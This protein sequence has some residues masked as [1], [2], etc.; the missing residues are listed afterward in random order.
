[1]KISGGTPLVGTIEISGAK[2]LALPALAASLLTDGNLSL[3]RVP[4]LEDVKSMLRL[5]V[6][7][8]VDMGD[9]MAGTIILTANGLKTLDAGY[10]FVRKMRGSIL[11]LGPLVARFRKAAVSLPGGC[12]IG[13]RGVDLHLKALEHMGA[14]ITIENGYIN[15]SA[16]NGLIGCDIILPIPTVTGTENI[17]M[18]ATLAK[19]ITRIINAA[20]EP[21]VAALA[22]LLIKMGAKI[23]GHGSSIVTIDGVDSL[24]GTD[25]TILP[26]R[27]EAGTYAIAAA[28]T[29]GKLLLKNCK[30]D[31]LAALFD[32]LHLAGVT[33]QVHREAGNEYE[34]IEVWRNIE[35]INP[36]SI[37]TT[38]FPGFATDLQAQFMTLMTICNGTAAITENIFE[39]RFMHVPELSR[40]GANISIHGKTA[41]VT[42]QPFLRGTNVMA[43]DLRASVSLVL[44]GLTAHGETIVN[45]LYH[46]D[47]GYENIDQKLRTCGA[48]IER[49]TV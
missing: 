16:P 12:A 44:A 43:T 49:F 27:I 28:L 23:T 9:L 37:Q 18:A 7:L 1:M 39:N 26:D 35:I 4:N 11:V 47:R 2:N 8:G 33:H 20:M 41:I 46:I 10:D 48:N 31:H 42:G 3:H 34:D 29:N 5:L 36:V 13:A 24:S 38:P 45:R 22:D 17:L 6:H 40:M 19:G 30:Y 21:E 14:S 15:A 25:F 32:A